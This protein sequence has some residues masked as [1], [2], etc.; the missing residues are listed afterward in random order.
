[1]CDD[2]EYNNLAFNEIHTKMH[3]IV[4][5]S[6]G[7]GRERP[8]EERLQFL[9]DEIATIK[10]TLAEI[11]GKLAEEGTERLHSKLLTEG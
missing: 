8:T 4:R 7:G 9:V 5:V 2:C 10:R 3:T 1:M 6:E 11:L